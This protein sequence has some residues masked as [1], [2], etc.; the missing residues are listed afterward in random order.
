MDDVGRALSWDALSAFLS[1]CGP[2]TAL[3]Q[4]LEPEIAP[5]AGTVK[6]NAL[7]ADI[8]DILQQINSN[9]VAL[10]ERKKSKK[11]D[12]YPRPGQ[13]KDKQKK[14]YGSGA[15]PPTEL[16]AWIEEKRR[17]KRHD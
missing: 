17:K 8:F 14:H 11:P 10:A 16:H 15:L 7:L 1:Q 5:W 9:L 6:T 12:K 2:D 3:A 4:E 13:Q